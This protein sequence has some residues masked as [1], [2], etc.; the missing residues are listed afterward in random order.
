[1]DLDPEAA[2]RRKIDELVA[3]LPPSFVYSLLS[4]IEQMDHEPA[5]RVRLVRQYVIEYL[6]RQRTNRA[7]RLFTALFEP[8]LVNDEALFHAGGPVPGLVERVDVGALWEVLSRDA[9]PLLA[10]EV[11]EVLDEAAAG[12]VIDRVLR[13][14]RALDLRERMR[15]A[16]V[17]HLDSVLAN[18]K[19][20]DG[21]LT[22]LSRSRT[23]RT[24][25]LSAFLDKPAPF[26]AETLE[27]LRDLLAHADGAVA[28]AA[29][30]LERMPTAC[31]DQRERDRLADAL[32][33]DTAA[34]RDRHPE[35]DRLGALLP[36]SVLN[37]RHNHAVAALYIRGAGGDAAAA[38][39]PVAALN[40]HYLGSLRAL[41]A[42]L[43]GV[44]K[45]NERVPGSPIRPT[46]KD[47]ARLDGLAQRI[48]GLLEA[49]NLAG[50]TED[51]RTEPTYRLAWEGAARVIAGR[52]AGVALER[53]TVLASGRRHAAS[54]HG[55]VLWLLRFLWGWYGMARSFEL[56]TFDLHAW[57]ETVLEEMRA[58]LERALKF[59]P[60]EP[61]DDRMAHILR[62]DAVCTVFDRRVTAWI[63]P[64]SHNMTQLVVHRLS[65]GAPASPEERAL[66]DDV[67]AGARA[68]VARNRYWKSHELMDLIELAE[69]TAG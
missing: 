2:L 25:M 5:E 30:A 37:V 33:A 64:S 3:R 54:D 26:A 41:T 45:L 20:L 8:F 48:A 52:V 59:E 38:V 39:A 49:L 63:P 22:T 28:L 36:L 32:A 57:R 46:P 24:R 66:I 35:A 6:N 23:R 58:H 21:L 9:F 56:E 12:D 34:L 29:R 61:L 19:T 7:R 51:R 40:A 65:A 42:G 13:T 27:L 1:M 62:I 47:R 50:L 67:V 10:I 55:E 11:Q 17:R 60:G 68:E 44:L 43:A 14:P 69:R 16:A 15:V 4:E 53:C 31:A 18:R